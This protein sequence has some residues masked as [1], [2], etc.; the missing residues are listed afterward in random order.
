MTI[1]EFVAF[2]AYLVMLTWP[3]IAFGWVTNMLQRGTASWTRM[4]DVMDTAPAMA[5]PPASPRPPRA[6]AHVAAPSRSAS[7]TF[8][9]DGTRRPDGHLAAH[10]RRAR[11]WRSSG[12]RARARSTLINLLPRLFEPPRGTV[13]IDGVDV[14]DIPLARAAR[15]DRV[16][17]RRS[18]SCSPKAW[19]D[20]I[21]FGAAER[22][23]R[24]AA[25]SGCRRRRVQRR[26]ARQGR[27]AIFRAGYETMVGE[28]G[29]TLS[30]GQKQRT[31]LARALMVDPRILILDDA[32]SAV[33]T[34]TEEE[35]LSRLR[36]VMRQRTSILVSH[37]V[38]TVRDADQIVVLS[39]RPHRGARDATT[40]CWPGRRLRRDAP[41]ADCWKTS[42][43]REA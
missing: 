37:R 15:R 27:R 39:G 1:G 9:Y 34:S 7:L 10:R 40:N 20:N 4:L 29:I 41:A 14:R 3:M 13:F 18:R 31:A 16:R 33:D 32:L 30:G 36:T 35:I 19:R 28:R 11:R 43:R 12:R 5:D 21:A 17:A 8:A 2:N 42:W 26:E 38:S 22:W 6:R 23:Q 24:T 25:A